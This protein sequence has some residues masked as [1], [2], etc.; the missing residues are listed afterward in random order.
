MLV[1]IPLSEPRVLKRKKTKQFFRLTSRVWFRPSVHTV[2]IVTSLVGIVGSLLSCLQIAVRMRQ[3]RYEK[4]DERK[5]LP[6]FLLSIN[7]QTATIDMRTHANRTDVPRSAVLH[8]VCRFAARC[9]VLRR[10]IRQPADVSDDIS[11]RLS[12]DESGTIERRAP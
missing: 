6:L 7:F 2:G 12:N 8:D 11:H 10:A 4:I 9:V 3:S 5:V 1:S